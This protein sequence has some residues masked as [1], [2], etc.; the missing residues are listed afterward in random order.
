[1]GNHLGQGFIE[2]ARDLQEIEPLLIANHI[3]VFHLS[4]ILDV[5]KSY[6]WFRFGIVF[7]KSCNYAM[8]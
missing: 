6:A 1:M 2:K 4:M 8:P 7:T 5:V 3:P